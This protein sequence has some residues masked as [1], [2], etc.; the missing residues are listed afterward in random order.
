MKSINHIPSPP[1]PSFTLYQIT[2]THCTCLTVLSSIIISKVNVQ[3]AFS[4]Y[5]CCGYTLPWSVQPLALLSLTPS[6]P[7][8]LF[9]SFQSIISSICYILC[10]HNEMYSDIVNSLLMHQTEKLLNCKRNHQWWFNDINSNRFFN[11]EVF[12]YFY[13]NYK[14]W[15]CWVPVG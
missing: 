5:P 12:L 3:R 15:L 11:C 10:L 1:S 7:P 14:V 2:S 8:P 13:F 6:L 4:M 9:N